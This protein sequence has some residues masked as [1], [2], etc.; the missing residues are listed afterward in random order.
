MNKDLIRT[1]LYQ[2]QDYLINE[3]KDA[4]KNN[5]FEFGKFYVEKK[6]EVT[7]LINCLEIIWNRSIY[8]IYY[9]RKINIE[10]ILKVKLLVNEILNLCYVIEK[11]KM[12]KCN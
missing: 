11:K 10:K 8:I 5:R 6:N 9:T 2:L 4:I 3:L 12:K 1:S 7:D